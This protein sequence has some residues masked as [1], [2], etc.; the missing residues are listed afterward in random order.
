MGKKGLGSRSGNAKRH[1]AMAFEFLRAGK[2]YQEATKLVPGLSI[3]K[4]GLAKA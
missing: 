3:S 2:S 1:I 4:Q